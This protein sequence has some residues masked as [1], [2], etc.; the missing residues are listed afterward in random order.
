MYLGKWKEVP[1]STKGGAYFKIVLEGARA[2]KRATN[3]T[4]AC[5]PTWIFWFISDTMPTGH[6]QA[7][8]PVTPRPSFPLAFQKQKQTNKTNKNKTKQTLAHLS[9]Y[10]ASQQLYTYLPHT[11]NEVLPVSK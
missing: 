4:G 5:L 10:P 7:T 6:L 2:P 1:A 3:N 8:S 9:N 11:E